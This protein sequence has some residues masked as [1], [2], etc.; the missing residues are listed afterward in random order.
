M[1]NLSIIDSLRRRWNRSVTSSILESGSLLNVGEGEQIVVTYTSA[2]DKMKIFAAF[3]REGLENGDLVDYCYPDEE[4][5]T[6]R[7]KLR[8]HGIDVEK[9][10]RDGSLNLD[11]LTEYFMAG[12]EFDKN[13]L[14]KKGLDDRAE[15][16]RK[17]YEHYRSLDDLGDFSF[18]NGQ[19]PTFIDYWD[20]PNWATTSDY[21][22]EILDYAPFVTELVAFDVEGVEETVL[23][24]MLKAF[25]MGN[26]SSTA[27]VDLLEDTNAFSKLVG[28]PHKKIIGRKFLL[29]FNPASNYEK[30]IEN[31]AKEA[32]ANVYPIFIVTSLR[33]SLHTHLA[34]QSTARFF[35][36]STFVSTPQ[37]ASKTEMLLPA[38]SPAL[39]L[40]SISKVLEENHNT[41][42]FLVF[43]KIS[44]LINLVGFEKTYKSL[45]YVSE[46]LF[47]TKTTALFL[48]NTSAHEL[49]VISQI[50]ALFPNLLTYDKDGLKI[51][52]IS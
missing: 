51:A 49:K 45:I 16:K 24:E 4:N 44:E 5:G 43:D 37:S 48:L 12:G 34:K 10:E 20:A 50:R 18:L 2:A 29:E 25:R 22:I 26:P 39:I 32:V 30:I 42:T 33:S 8:E 3:L 41:N 7:A 52:K 23:D 35:L 1:P 27:F 38:T 28:I 13:K 19:W 40:D 31:F 11:S 6:V 17:G 46:M 15:A 21:D 14:V 9:Y 47:Q 36:L